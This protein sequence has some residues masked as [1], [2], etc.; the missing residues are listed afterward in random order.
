MCVP[1]R[2]SCRR[3]AFRRWS[4][5]EVTGL[6]SSNAFQYTGRENDGTGFYYYRARYYNPS[7]QRFL[8][9]DPLE[10]AGGKT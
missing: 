3:Y 8:G 5:S 1:R 9:A 7:P 4:P 10:S 6:P 2:V